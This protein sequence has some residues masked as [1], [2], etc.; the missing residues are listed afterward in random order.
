MFI[1]MNSTISFMVGNICG[2]ASKYCI[3]IGIFFY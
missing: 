3:K 2:E 1:S